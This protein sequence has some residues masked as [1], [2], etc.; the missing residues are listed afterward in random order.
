MG[1]FDYNLTVNPTGQIDDHLL[2]EFLDD[3][4]IGINSNEDDIA[5]NTAAIAAIT[6]GKLLQIIQGTSTT[7][8]TTTST[9]YV[10]TNLS[11]NITPSSTSNKV[12]VFASG[13]LFTSNANTLPAITIFGGG[14]ALA[15]ELARNSI[16]GA[17]SLDTPA[18]MI[19]LDS[20]STTSQVSYQV[21]LKRLGS[22]NNVTYGSGNESQVMIAMEIAG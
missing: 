22:A 1:D 5:T 11:I 19:Y 17:T 7:P 8:L 21:Y 20:P 16:A 18:T 9:T 2:R 13:T 10:S 14:S 12:V 6:S 3:I 4:K 15:T